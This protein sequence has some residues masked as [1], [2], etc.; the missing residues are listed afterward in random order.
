MLSKKPAHSN[1][2]RILSEDKFNDWQ[3][4]PMLNQT[5]YVWATMN[6]FVRRNTKENI[7]TKIILRDF[8]SCKKIEQRIR[9]WNLYN[10]GN[11]RFI[12]HMLGV[13]KFKAVKFQFGKLVY[14]QISLNMN[15]KLL[16]LNIKL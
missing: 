7:R 5:E 10:M 13:L 3:Y 6:T 11:V 4:N 2:E 1:I 9:K 16:K 14:L 12:N 15:I 8:K